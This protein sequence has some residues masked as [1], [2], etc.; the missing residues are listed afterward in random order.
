MKFCQWINRQ[1]LSNYMWLS[2]SR[3][4][5]VIHVE[6]RSYTEPADVVSGRRKFSR[7]ACKSAFL[8]RWWH[9]I[10]VIRWTTTAA[11]TTTATIIIIIYKQQ[12]AWNDQR[13]RGCHHHRSVEHD[14]APCPAAGNGVC[15]IMCK[16]NNWDHYPKSTECMGWS[17]EVFDE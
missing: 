10:M 1:H 5:T 3:F 7:P 12:S 15:R 11:A 2:I 8:H 6:S 13:R 16:S 4:S 14:L 17:E 9:A